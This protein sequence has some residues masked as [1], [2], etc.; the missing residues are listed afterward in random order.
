MTQN[1]GGSNIIPDQ[2]ETSRRSSD[3]RFDTVEKVKMASFTVEVVYMG[4]TDCIGEESS[5]H[6]VMQPSYGTGKQHREIL[7]RYSPIEV[8]LLF[9]SQHLPSQVKVCEN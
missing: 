2:K 8:H 7:L 6:R 3:D 4:L 9:E 1:P 5:A